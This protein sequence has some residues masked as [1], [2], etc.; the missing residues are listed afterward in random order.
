MGSLFVSLISIL[1]NKAHIAEAIH[2]EADLCLFHLLFFVNCLFCVLDH[3]SSLGAVFFFDSVKFFN[4]YFT[5]GIIVVQNIFIRSNIFHSLVILC[6]KSLNF[7][8]DQTVQ[9]HFQNGCSLILRKFQILCSF[10]T[11][12]WLEFD[13]LCDTLYQTLFNLVTALAASKDLNDQIDYITGFDKAFLDFLFLK[14][15]SQKSL[16]LAGSHLEHKIHMVL[17]HLLQA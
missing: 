11:G 3:S 7:Q 1:I 4:N 6:L 16:V 9:T 10:L 8:S 2:K 12:F 17:Y 14:L 15:F 13:S 5:H